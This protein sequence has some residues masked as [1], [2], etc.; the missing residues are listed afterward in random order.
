MST[1]IKTP[2]EI[3][4]L[5]ES[6]RRL[7][8]A[9]HKVAEQVRPGV[10]TK[11]LDML[12]QQII[13]EAGDTP[14]FLGYKPGGAHKPYPAALCVS[15]NDEVVHGIPDDVILQEGDIVGIDLGVTHKGMITDMAMTVA[16]GTADPI[17]E[18]LMSTTKEALSAGIKA[19]R[20]GAR[21]GDISYAIEGVAK[22]SG[23]A[24]VEELGGHGVGRE[25]HEEPY[26]S[27]F[28]DK[29]TGPLLKPGMVLALEPIFNEGDRGVSLASDGY[30]FETS[31]GKRS[32]HFEHTILITEG[33][34]EILTKF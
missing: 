12:A 33:D 24:V 25:V 9:L 17:A 28:G 26:I 23:F 1:T 32:A 2:E 14:S 10:T 7:S 30:T 34:A 8:V 21:V 15:V 5:R 11:E 31:D 19:A 29:G 16:V 6:G 18:K 4:L 3:E 27:N 13:K 20:G 22:R